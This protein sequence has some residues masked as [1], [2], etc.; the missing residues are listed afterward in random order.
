[1]ELGRLKEWSRRNLIEFK[2]EKWKV[3]DLV[4]NNAVQ[5]GERPAW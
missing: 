5:A 1:M 4:Q 3:P 2:E